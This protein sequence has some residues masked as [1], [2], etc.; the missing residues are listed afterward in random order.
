MIKATGNSGVYSESDV[1]LEFVDVSFSYSSG[2]SALNGV[3]L[4]I[5]KGE[6]VA[7]CG[8][9]GSGKTTMLKLAAGLFAPTGGSINLNGCLQDTVNRKRAFRSIGF[10][11][12]DSEDQLF[13]SNVREDIA[14]GPV[15][16]ELCKE[17][18]EERVAYALK[19]LRIEKL[20]DRP[21]H[22]LS[23]GEKRR[24]ALAG[25]V[26]MR[27]PLLVLDEPI[28]GLDPQTCKE[29]IEWISELREEGFTFLTVTHEIA[30]VPEFAEKLLL[31]KDGVVV[32]EGLSHEVL[33]DRQALETACL[34]PPDILRFFHGLKEQ[35]KLSQTAELPLTVPEALERVKYLNLL[36]H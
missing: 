28:S 26:A 34:Q 29:V 17:E 10:L 21:I 5:R 1:I 16:L 8:P 20:A 18:V 22:H 35:G 32:V 15:N 23:G 2:I 36:D 27:V 25:L 14:F 24:V 19:T 6:S 7:V 13:C 30:R 4:K 9:N 11:F 33:N 12:Q 31:L 3:N